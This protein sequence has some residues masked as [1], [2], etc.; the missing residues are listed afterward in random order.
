MLTVKNDNI[1]DN[2]KYV[3]GKMITPL[4]LSFFTVSSCYHFY[5]IIFQC[6]YLVL[7]LMLSFLGCYHL[8]YLML[9]LFTVSKCYHFYVIIFPSTYFVLSFMLSFDVIIYCYHFPLS[10]LGHAIFEDVIIFHDVNAMITI[11]D[12][13]KWIHKW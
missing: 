5:V 4:M 13:I 12:N 2:T 1:N 10:F 8:C 9:S 6:T 11:N 7:S 3:Q